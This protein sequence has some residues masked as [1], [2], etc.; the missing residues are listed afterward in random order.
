MQVNRSQ[1]TVGQQPA[2]VFPLEKNS[3]DLLGAGR[4]VH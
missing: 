4:I 1:E 2:V 3:D